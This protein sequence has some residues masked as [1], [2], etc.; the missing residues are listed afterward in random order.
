MKAMDIQPNNSGDMNKKL[1]LRPALRAPRYRIL[2]Q[3]FTFA[4]K[5]KKMTTEDLEDDMEKYSQ[6]KNRIIV[7]SLK[8]GGLVSV[9]A[10]VAGGV[11]VGFGYTSGCLFG[12]AYL[13][14]LGKRVDVIGYGISSSEASRGISKKDEILANG[15]FYTPLALIFFL[16]ARHSISNS[17]F[18]DS[19]PQSSGVL[20]HLL[21]KDEFLAAIAGFLTHRFTL[22]YTEIL[23]QMTQSDWLSFLPGSFAETFRQKESLAAIM[24]AG[25]AGSNSG[26]QAKELVTVIC[27]TGPQASGRSAVVNKFLNLYAES[28]DSQS[29]VFRKTKMFLQPCNFVTTDARLAAQ[30][31]DKYQLISKTEFD[32]LTLTPSLAGTNVT[33]I[34]AQAGQA[35]FIGNYTSVFDGDIPVCLLA[36]LY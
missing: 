14:L 32:A 34:S 36:L 27:V 22:F 24:S 11:D 15:R 10:W 19:S 13:Y 31:P 33:A 12:A 23:G 2:D 3:N 6:L 25:A 9:A 16:A 29:K 30:S 20:F 5:L 35:V 21:E 26:V 17:I 18:G 8:L 1:V 4:T 7:D 28:I